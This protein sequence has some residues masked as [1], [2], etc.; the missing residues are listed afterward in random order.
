MDIARELKLF[1]QIAVGN[2][3]ILSDL[4]LSGLLKILTIL[5]SRSQLFTLRFIDIFP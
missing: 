2:L 5:I 3:Q 4:K 1:Y